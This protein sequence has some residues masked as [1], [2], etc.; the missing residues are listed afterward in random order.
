[1]SDLVIE[2]EGLTKEFGKT[3][4]V[5]D[6]TL[7]IPRGTVYGLLGRNGCG[8]TTTI[9]L[10]MGLLRPT[11][12][13]C[14]LLGHPSADLPPA[15]RERVGYLIEGHPLY[16]SWKIRQ[17]E[18]FTRSFYRAWD[19]G[20]FRQVLER[21]ELD[22]ARRAWS[23]S[24]GERG[25][26]ALALVLAAGP[27][28][29]VLDDP[30]LGLDALARR[31]FLETVIE[32]IQ[33]EGRTILFSSHNLADVERVADRIGVMDRGVLRADCPTH[34]FLDRVRKVEIAPP[35]TLEAIVSFPGLLDYERKG[36]RLALTLVNLDDERRAR[37]KALSPDGL[38]EFPLNLEDAFIAYT[39]SRPLRG[40]Q[41]G[42]YVP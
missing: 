35:A 13:T 39:G 28:V 25:M 16:R 3:R 22:P 12:G 36:E 18:S 7:R 31:R 19:A 6:L 17:L 37:L 10:L 8:K 11:R 9:K 34:E 20:F 41:G 2:C 27:E 33:R 4:A 5:W 24:R 32:I 21:F 38:E 15:V 14:R 1:M 29:L 30:A 26:V 40:G 23:L 42:S